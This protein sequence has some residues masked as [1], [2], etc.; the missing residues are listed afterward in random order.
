[1]AGT[2]FALKPGM[3]IFDESYVESLTRPDSS[4]RVAFTPDMA[5]RIPRPSELPYQLEI[6][7]QAWTQIGTISNVSFDRIRERIH[8]LA[9][10]QGKRASGGPQETT[11]EC[12][13]LVMT[14]TVNT[15]FHMITLQ[16]ICRKQRAA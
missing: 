14:F 11:L 2:R 8:A 3:Q 5:S 4:R 10:Q 1:M 16:R 12:E 13:G 7:P 9:T 6:S 15:T